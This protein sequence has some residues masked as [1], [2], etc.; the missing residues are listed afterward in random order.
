MEDV[1]LKNVV[2][3]EALSN[4]IQQKARAEQESTRME[5]VLQKESQ[6]AKRK[7]IEAQGIADFQPIVSDGITPGVLQWKGIQATEKLAES[8]NSKVVIVGNSKDSLPIILGN[9]GK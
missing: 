4:A 1:L 5:F 6:E 3:P 9:D 7:A 8:P 2:L